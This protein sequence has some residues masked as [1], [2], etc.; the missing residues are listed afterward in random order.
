MADQILLI[1]YCC[2]WQLIFVLFDNDFM[3]RLVVSDEGHK[4]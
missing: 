2:T 1:F 3:K 4:V